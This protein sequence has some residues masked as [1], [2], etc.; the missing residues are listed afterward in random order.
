MTAAAHCVVTEAQRIALP[1]S[2]FRNDNAPEQPFN[3]AH[4]KSYNTTPHKCDLDN[5]FI[6]CETYAQ[7]YNG[8]DCR[9][10][11]VGK[12][13]K[14]NDVRFCQRRTAA[15]P[16]DAVLVVQLG[17]H[18]LFNYSSIALSET[19]SRDILLFS[20]LFYRLDDIKTVAA[21]S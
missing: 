18:A 19:E 11:S 4:L 2:G 20:R 16:T 6:I 15:Q 14:V 3:W 13:E 1:Q 10:P 12:L 17:M 8:Y 21:F 7:P 9:K 5:A